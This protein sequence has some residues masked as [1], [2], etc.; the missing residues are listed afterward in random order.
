MGKFNAV[1]EYLEN[2]FIIENS[3]YV[4]ISKQNNLNSI[5]FTVHIIFD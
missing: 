4:C 3:Q 1:S 2:K 5:F